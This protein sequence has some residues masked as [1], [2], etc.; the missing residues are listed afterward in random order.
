VADCLGQAGANIVQVEHQRTF[1]ELPLQAVDAGFVLQ[2]RGPAHA[3]EVIE[4]L[5]RAGFPTRRV[6]AAG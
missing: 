3:A 5:E 2:T 6:D 1:T 4:R